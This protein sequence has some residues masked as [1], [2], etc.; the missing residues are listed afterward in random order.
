MSLA[1]NFFYT[2]FW[3]VTPTTTKL[4]RFAK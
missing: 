1:T 4:Q 2:Y 3:G